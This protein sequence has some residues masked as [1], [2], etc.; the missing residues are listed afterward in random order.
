MAR[1]TRTIAAGA[2]LLLVL[3]SAAS[4]APDNLIQN[5]DFDDSAGGWVFFNTVPSVDGE[6]HGRCGS[7]S[8]M[9]VAT[10]ADL[11]VQSEVYRCVT[12]LTGLTSYS[13]DGHVFFPAQTSSGFAFL[14]VDWRDSVADCNGN[15]TGYISGDSQPSSQSGVWVRHE[16]L[17]LVS[18][19]GTHA[20]WVGVLYDHD[21][22]VSP[23][24]VYLDGFH[25]VAAPGL[26]FNDGFENNSTCRW[27]DAVP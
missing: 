6:D 10:Q 2:E 25:M 12:G 19:A 15:P 7:T 3:A 24:T 18:P 16:M 11:M 17:D 23:M 5:G 14:Y 8:N 20:A 4:A 1:A 26:L 21:S 22:G 9:L 13:L 27:S